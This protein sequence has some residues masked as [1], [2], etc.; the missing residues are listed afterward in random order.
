[1]LLNTIKEAQLQARKNQ[2]V[3][4]KLLT[5][6]YSEALVPG[7]NNGNRESTDDE[8]MTVIKKFIKG[9]DESI[10][11][12]TRASATLYADRDERVSKLIAEKQVL[13]A[14]LPKQLTDDE[15]KRELI[16]LKAKLGTDF[17]I[18]NIMDSFNEKFKD[19]F[20]SRV[21]AGLAKQAIAGEL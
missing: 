17:T 9:I 3:S 19:M 14:F 20:T 10:L 4:A 6:L 16:Q 12:Y 5:T 13:E 15:I 18:K 21:L 7:K 11:T 2:D 8:V 1:M